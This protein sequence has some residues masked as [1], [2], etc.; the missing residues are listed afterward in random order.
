V[1]AAAVAVA[2]DDVDGGDEYDYDIE[3][4]LVI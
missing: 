1:V 3:Q 2:A 4:G